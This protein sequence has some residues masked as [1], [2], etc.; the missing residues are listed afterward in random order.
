MTGQAS[1]S[2]WSSSRWWERRLRLAVGTMVTP[3]L[4]LVRPLPDAGES[5]IWVAD[6]LGL[7]LQVAVKFAMPKSTDAAQAAFDT[8]RFVQQAQVAEQLADPN[9]LGVYEHGIAKGGVPFIVTELLEGRSLRRRLMQGSLKMS[10]ARAIIGQATRTLAKAHALGLVHGSLCPE[11]MFLTEVGGQPFVKLANF[12]DVPPVHA[13]EHPP[14]LPYVSPERLLQGT[15]VSAAADLWALSVIAYEMLTTILPFEAATPAGVMVAICNGHFSP[16]SDYRADLPPSID[17][18]FAR[19]LALEPQERFREASELGHTFVAALSSPELAP[20]ASTVVGP[21]MVEAQDDDGDE[22]TARWD[23]PQDW[24]ANYASPEA[25]RDAELARRAATAAV[26]VTGTAGPLPRAALTRTGIPSA[27][28]VLSGA[29]FGGAGALMPLALGSRD[30]TH[31]AAFSGPP[32]TQGSGAA[33][34]FDRIRDWS[35]GPH[36]GAFGVRALAAGALIGGAGVLG[37]WAYQAVT[38]DREPALAPTSEGQAA[39]RPS[40]ESRTGAAASQ[41]RE[42]IP[43]VDAADLP[44][45]VRPEQLPPAPDEAAIEIDEM[46]PAP[47][48]AQA[49]GAPAPS[50]AQQRTVAPAALRTPAPVPP[51]A[52]AVA[53]APAASARAAAPPAPPAARNEAPPSRAT[54]AKVSSNCN[55]P[56]FFDRNNIRRLKLEC[57]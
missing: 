33:V 53:A 39:L 57:L 3:Q 48:R 21:S 46:P 9:V 29:G 25:A 20:A 17:A 52:R 5:S 35:F 28:A 38:S 19:A 44:V 11:H 32:R 43:V 1:P 23:L 12:G 26:A 42:N 50:A 4:R 13:G 2:Q 18:W 6:H 54:Q 56:Y 7:Q 30:S 55:P 41:G 15:G 45:I 8:D 24:A 51:P 27:T 22:L 47:A 10:E 34:L 31:G 37:A 49:A 36:A 40:N 16:P 14:D